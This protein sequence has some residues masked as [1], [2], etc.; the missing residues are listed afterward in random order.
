[1]AKIQ[2]VEPNI[3]DLANSWLK[4]YKLDY[5][6]EQES[7]N[8]EI[9]QALNDYYSK[10]GG[11]GGNRPDAKLL[12]Q[13]KNL[14]NYP[15]LIEYK[16]YKDKLVKLDSEGKVANKTA[17][18]QPDFKNINSYAVNGAVHYANAL[19]HYTSYTDIIAIGMTGFKD[20]SGNLEYEIGVYYVSKSNFG[21][22]QKVDDYT[23][24]S[25]LKKTNFDKFID[26][27]KK[28]RL[29]QDEIERLKEQREQE[30]NTSLVKLNND[31]YQNEK[32]LSERD[33][34]YLVAASIIATLGVPGKVAALEKQ[35][36]KSSIEEGNRD[37]DIIL[38]KIKA[39]LNEK[40]LP[41]EKRE[42][43][44]RTLQNTLTTDNINKVD[45]GESQLKRVFT[46]IVDDLG[47]Y[48]KI[49]LT[50]DFTGKLFNEMYS[51]LGFSQDKL[52]DVVLTPAYVA[53]L[54]A[55]LARVNKD[56]YVWD[57]ATDSAGLL[58][59]A[60]NEM[61]NDA[62][63]KIKSPDEFLRKSA[64]IKANQLLGLEIL[65]EVYM[66]AILNMILMGDGSSN[67]LNKDS[68]KEFD[69]NYGFG[70]TDEKFPADA[71]VLNPPYSAPGN[72]MIFVEKALSMMSKG[73]A[74]I[75][76]QNSA[77]SGKATEY[78]K[79]ILKHSTLLASIKMP[80]DLF[81]GKSSVQTNVYVFRVGET[82]Q[83]DDVVKFIDFSNDGY[84]RTNRKKASC[85]LRDTD[86]AKERY[87]ELVD[88][89]RFGKSKLNIFTEKEYYEG[90]I[91]PENG[92]DWN[93]S[94]PIDTK[95]TLED[96]KKTVSDYLAWE[97]SMLLKN[98]DLEDDSLK[99]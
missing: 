58:V 11:V 56:S 44:V 2:S 17:K 77:G 48:Y 86:R 70:K 9:D 94:A 29:T 19:L 27:V 73:Y 23:D 3:A 31:I 8:T 83:K 57:F 28:L 96:F 55:R 81:I 52:N 61:L 20:D 65:S 10:N 79:K 93:Q 45:N 7:L 34:V 15:I 98:Q 6:L 89:V 14:V 43:I 69:G 30:I 71:F 33:R 92:A 78:N 39:F 12:L 75:I 42:L 88:L 62:K 80:I 25:F 37:G 51:W 84:T 46:K 35:E 21:I 64:E 22:G 4:S 72:G 91:D 49:G 76:I 5:K 67:I 50:T 40:N 63:E 53:T 85:N 41:Q 38:R 95:P 36:L 66:L 99:K 74:A 16:G 90:K 87:Q 32:G 97:V 60:M 18:N 47:I 68:L 13:D 1:M 26:K 54:L 82:H 24:F 59:A